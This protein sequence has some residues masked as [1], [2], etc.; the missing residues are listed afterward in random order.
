MK[1]LADSKVEDFLVKLVDSGHVE[2][3]PLTSIKVIEKQFLSL[4][5]QVWSVLSA[6]TGV[7]TVS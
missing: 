2:C 7:F 1:S 3:V 5:R 6:G 4:P